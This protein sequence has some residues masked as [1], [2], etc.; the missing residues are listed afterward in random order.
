MFP[1]HLIVLLPVND[2]FT[3]TNVCDLGY[4]HANKHPEAIATE[5]VPLTICRDVN[6][7]S[8]V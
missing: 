7:I 8:S 6:Q 1:T 3:C 2:H 4:W 5:Y